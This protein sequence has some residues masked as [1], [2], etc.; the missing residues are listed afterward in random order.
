[1]DALLAIRLPVEVKEQVG[2]WAKEDD[3]SVSSF[4]RRLIEAERARR[5]AQSTQPKNQKR[6]TIAA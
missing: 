2:Q 6:E 5:V 3:R 4:L 1:M